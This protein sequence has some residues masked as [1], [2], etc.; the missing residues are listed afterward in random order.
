[1]KSEK[2]KEPVMKGNSL[3]VLKHRYLKKD[4][5]PKELFWR[6]AKNI[7]QVDL[8]YTNNVHQTAEE[9]YKMMSTS[10]FLPNSPT[11]LNAG[12]GFQQLSAC[13]V[14]PLEDS[15]DSIFTTLKHAVI[16]QSVG[17]GTGFNFSSI[18]PAL[19]KVGNVSDVA[20]GPIHYI[21]TYDTAL[22]RIMQGSKRHGAN[23]GVLNIDHPDI[24][25][26]IKLKSEDGRIK[27]FNVSV[28]VTDEFMQ[29]VIEDDSYVLVNPRNKQILKRIKANKIFDMIA[30]CAWRTGDPGLLFLNRVKESNT[31]PQIGEINATNPCGEQPL[32][33]YESCNLGSINLSKMV[34]DGEIN[35]DKLKNT[36]HE[37]VHF[38]DNVIDVNKYPL[39]EIEKM[40]TSNRKIGLGVMGFADMLF[41]L[42]IVYNSK[43]GEE[44][45]KK[46][47]EF[48]TK[49]ANKASQD[50]AEIRGAFPNFNKSIFR[51]PR[52]NA[53][54][55]TIAP[56]GSI[57]IIG[58]CSSGI[59]PV[60]SLVTKANV[61]L[62]A[63]H[64]G[65]SITIVN[66]V[67]EKEL[68]ERGLYSK[69]LMDK[70]AK[71][72]TIKKTDLPKDIKEIFI[73]SHDISP[74]WHI[75]IQAAFQQHTENAVSKT[76]NFPNNATI[77]EIKEAFILAW[78]SGCKGTTIYRDRS[79]K[80]Q[81]L[82]K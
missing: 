67:F 33:A 10:V 46:V 73:T 39:P 5:T 77:D 58:G 25:D 44:T 61:L 76:V 30:E 7:A 82:S 56:T 53:T 57:S 21:E 45:A 64:K 71:Q 41:K 1:M 55:T 28:G 13:F 54:V 68:K 40:S 18:R 32:L 8:R 17:G 24:V 72:G 78:K 65:S 19:D 62:D 59:E 22:N 70:I 14:L 20:A 38:L 37:A 66:P 31:T 75:R 50:L 48:I 29:K 42:K 15:L 60:F 79:K 9:F 16:V 11:L 80:N 34:E 2:L 26:F 36:I 51:V 63:D 23:M 52:R 81:T 3:F 47:M 69:E 6:V 49:Q 35:W 27:N 4:E 74:Q 43:Q 12:R